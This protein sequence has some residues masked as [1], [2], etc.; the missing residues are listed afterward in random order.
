MSDAI[1]AMK[2]FVLPQRALLPYHIAASPIVA[3]ALNAYASLIG[4]PEVD[5]LLLKY[6]NRLSDYLFI[7]SALPLIN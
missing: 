5:A 4:K 3:S 1:P 6:L 2:S 7:L